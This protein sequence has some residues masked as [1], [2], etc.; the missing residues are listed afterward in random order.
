MDRKSIEIMVILLALIFILYYYY[1]DSNPEPKQYYQSIEIPVNE[2]EIIK[3]NKLNQIKIKIAHIYK[4][5]LEICDIWIYNNRNNSLN[6]IEIP[7]FKIV[8]SEKST[9]VENKY[10]IHFL[11]WDKE[12]E[13]LYDDNTLVAVSIHELAHI[14]CDDYIEHS[15]KFNYIESELLKIAETINVYNPKIQVDQS[16][17]CFDH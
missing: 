13:R 11:V 3:K 2:K 6:Q 1:R 10:I 4:I 7:D 5:L 14:L 8:L 9:H 16:Y 15:H 17:P 12:N